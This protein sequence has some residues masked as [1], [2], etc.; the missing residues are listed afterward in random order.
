VLD[1]FPR[2]IAQAEASDDLLHTRGLEL[3]HAI[4]L[5]VDEQI[6]LTRVMARA[7]EAKE[8]GE[9]VRSDDNHETLRIRLDAYKKQTAPLI[10]YYRSKDILQEHRWPS[11]R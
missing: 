10:D 3:D 7:R 8:R 2:T 4:E 6:L 5:Q 9:Q 11:A 1:G